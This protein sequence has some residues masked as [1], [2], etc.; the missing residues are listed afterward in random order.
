MWEGISS[1]EW[2][3]I[4]KI[5]NEAIIVWALFKAALSLTFLTVVSA[6]SRKENN[7]MKT[8]LFFI[9]PS[10]FLAAPVGFPAGRP[11]LPLALLGATRDGP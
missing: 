8:N 3:Q 9:S 11:P 1:E 4:Y 6:L 2:D 10:D 7:E 5:N